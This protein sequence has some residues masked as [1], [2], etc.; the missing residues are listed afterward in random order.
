MTKAQAYRN[1]RIPGRCGYGIDDSEIAHL[2]DLGL[3]IDDIATKM[4]VSKWT[5]LAHLKKLGLRRTCRH[6]ITNSN[7]FAELT[8]D[9][10]YWAGFIAADGF[11]KT[12]CQQ[13]GVELSVLDVKHLEDLCRFVGRDTVLYYRKRQG[14]SGIFEY[15]HVDFHSPKLTT[16]LRNNFKIVPRKSLILDPPE[17]QPMRRHFIR[18]YFD[19]DGSIGWHKH[20]KT[21]RFSICSGSKHFLEWILNTMCE[22][23]GD[24][25]QRAVSKRK[26]SRVHVL[27]LSEDVVVR[28]M[29][30]LYGSGGDALCLKRKLEKFHECRDK[31]TQKRINRQDNRKSLVET[32]TALYTTGLTY[33]E[34]AEKLDFTIE[35]V[36][37]YLRKTEIKKRGKAGG[38]YARQMRRRDVEMLNAYM[39][40][41][42]ASSIAE[43]F[44]L[45]KSAF[46]VAI[47]R[48]KLDQSYGISENT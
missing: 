39:S 31:L 9:S 4:N 5:V 25:R 27:E 43:R 47:R 10:C 35:K 26:N 15:V 41:E 2:F 6:Q 3:K 36:S 14:K 13:F 24:L 1:C 11:V 17:L 19:G 16:D 20:N 37:Y 30:W 28:V 48:A 44:D 22:E 8:I 38:S 34:I 45:T 33:R 32:M 21:M 12:G 46:W 29:E 18:G 23:L 40:G 42:K 7:V